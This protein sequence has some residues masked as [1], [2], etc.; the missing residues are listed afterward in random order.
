M[1]EKLWEILPQSD[2]DSLNL[3]RRCAIGKL[4]ARVLAARGFSL[5]ETLALLQTGED[6][7]HDPFLLPDMQKA[8][9]IIQESVNN[10][11]K[12][13]IFG[14]YDCD[15][16]TATVMMY[17]YLVNIGADVFFCLP[18]REKD[19]YGLN[20]IVIDEIC[21]RNADL[22][23]TVDNGISSIEEASYAKS[24]GIKMVI[25]DHHTVGEAL[26]DALAIVD[27]HRADSQYPFSDLCGAGVAFKLLSALEGDF[28]TSLLEQYGDIL[29]IGTIADLVTLRDENRYFV[30]RGIELL[31]ETVHPGIRILMEKAGIKNEN[32]QAE[33]ISFGIAPRINAAGR[34]ADATTAVDLILE[35]EA[36]E[37]EKIVSILCQY[38]EERRFAEQE[39]FEIIKDYLRN[40]REIAASRIVIINGSSW[41]HGVAGIVSSRLVDI[42]HKP[43][44]VI[45]EEDGLARGSGRSVEGFS[46]IEAINACSQY[47]IRH[48]G[49]PM[50]CGVTLD[51]EKIP[52]FRK[53]MQEYAKTNYTEMPSPKLLID[54]VI[55]TSLLVPSEVKALEVLKPFGSGNDVPVFAILDVTIDNVISL[56]EGKHT[57]LRVIK[58]NQSFFVV[59]FSAN[60][61]TFPYQKGDRVDIAFNLEINSYQGE[62]S[63]SIKLKGIRPAGSDNNKLISEF[64][65]YEKFLRGELVSNE[66]C[67]SRSDAAII[68]KELLKEPQVNYE[69]L[70]LYRKL[71]L[72]SVMSFAKYHIALDALN[73]L[74]MI[75]IKNGKIGLI[76]NP[77]RKDFNKAPVLKKFST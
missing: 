76:S 37:A 36:T 59:C 6:S 56:S 40:N 70:N 48:G 63:V 25:T 11:E 69:I 45:T 54:S 27:P 1:K 24:L 23:I 60:S 41:N 18:K 38:N 62:D 50:A 53:A 58:G 26:P 44:I 34:M 64:H 51:V 55:D 67:P 75:T 32:I 22:I 71:H 68:Y 19:G 43:C 61:K 35:E 73:E 39:A 30:K 21:S 3:M 29:A 4:P 66:I 28:G 52:L 7:L 47:L 20:K 65:D 49:H 31:K 14:D 9:D 72:E 46:L 8:V 33:N 57:K 17:D 10:G 42:L 12:I 2:E 5:E 77:T 15:G 74:G 13:C 16:I